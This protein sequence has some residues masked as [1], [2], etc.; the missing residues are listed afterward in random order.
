LAGDVDLSTNSALVRT[1][2]TAF[3]IADG[4]PVSR[5]DLIS[6]IW[7]DPP[8]SAVDNIRLH[9][10]RLRKVLASANLAE[11][12][13]TI[14]GGGGEGGGS[15]YRLLIEPGDLDLH[16]FHERVAQSQHLADRGEIAYAAVQMERALQLWRG[17]AGTDSRGSQRLALRLDALNEQRLLAW[18]DLLELRLHLVPPSRVTPD[19]YALIAESPLRERSHSLLMRALYL[20]GD[21]VGALAAYDNA[22]NLLAEELGLDPGPELRRIHQAIIDHNQSIILDFNSRLLTK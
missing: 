13:T 3:L 8:A 21:T 12:L 4:R 2:L 18:E 7:Q 17:P 5:T 22:R 6:L 16:L 9:I 20:S 14:R 1:L 10:R 19:L 15:A 11:R